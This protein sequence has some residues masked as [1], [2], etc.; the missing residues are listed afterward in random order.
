M[1]DS[2][3]QAASSSNEKDDGTLWNL[4]NLI[5]IIALSKWHDYR[6]LYIDLHRQMQRS[7]YISYD[8][9]D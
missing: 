5:I 3:R 4:Y 7:E 9:L 1:V 8:Q 6:D 2:L